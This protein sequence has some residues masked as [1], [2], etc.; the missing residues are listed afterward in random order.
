YGDDESNS[1]TSSVTVVH[2]GGRDSFGRLSGI[3]GAHMGK[4]EYIATDTTNQTIPWVRKTNDNGS[5]T[6]FVASGVKRPA[7]GPKRTVD[8]ID[9]YN[10]A[11]RD[12]DTPHNS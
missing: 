1:Q 12:F 11:A 5:V 3:H 6:E 2:V 8:C 9:C 10:P 7:A 4:I